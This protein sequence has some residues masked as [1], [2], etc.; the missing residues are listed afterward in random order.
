[1][2]GAIHD[3]TIAAADPP[4]RWVGVDMEAVTG[5]DSTA[6]ES[7]LELVAEV[8]RRDVAFAVARLREPVAE[9]LD[10]GEVLDFVGRD[11]AYLQVDD[12]VA[13]LRDAE[14]PVSS[15]HEDRP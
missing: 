10:R 3:A 6:T 1:M 15:P 2:H 8:H 14:P 9:Y 4:A 7:L 12:A 11:H 5:V 13:A